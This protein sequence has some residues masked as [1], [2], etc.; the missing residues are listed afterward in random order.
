MCRA[1][2]NMFK[3]TGGPTKVKGFVHTHRFCQSVTL[4]GQGHI[5]HINSDTI[6]E[7]LAKDTII[8]PD[9]TMV[10]GQV[11]G[12]TIGWNRINRRDVIPS[13]FHCHQSSFDLRVDEASEIW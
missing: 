13:Q 1:F 6:I 3:K 12:P 11:Q 4:V 10:I 8:K 2:Q 7:R 5:P 9:L